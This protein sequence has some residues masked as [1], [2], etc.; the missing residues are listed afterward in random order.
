MVFPRREHLGSGGADSVPMIVEVG[1][2][3]T[4]AA[5]GPASDEDALCAAA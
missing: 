3:M 4:R 1:V 2:V 5:A